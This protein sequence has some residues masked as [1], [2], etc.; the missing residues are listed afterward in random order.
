MLLKK[1]NEDTLY[2]DEVWFYCGHMP[3]LMYCH[4]VH[5]EALL[6]KVRSKN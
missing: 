1:N 2:A 4:S 3:Q 5:H 6:E